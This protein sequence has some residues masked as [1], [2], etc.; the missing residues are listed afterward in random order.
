MN[1]LQLLG[2]G[3]LG[4]VIIEFASFAEHRRT[5]IDQ[6]PSW[7]T[8]WVYWTCAVGSI[9]LGGLSAAGFI[10]HGVVHEFMVPIQV[11]MAAPA[12]FNI[13]GRAGAPHTGVGSHN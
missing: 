8:G 9:L 6:L 3:F 7:L 1:W 2:W 13:G 12:I 5:P 10:P 11:G 4:G